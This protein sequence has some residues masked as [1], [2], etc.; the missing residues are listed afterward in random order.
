MV[1]SL[2]YRIGRPLFF[3][4]GLI[5]AVGRFFIFQFHLIPL[6]FKRPF[7]FGLMVRQLEAIGA[8]SLLVVGLTAVFTGMVMAIQL[9][10]AFNKFGAAEMMGYAIFLA[11]GRELGPVFTALML[12]SRAVS[13]MAA[14]LGTMRVTEQIDAI[15]VLSVDS[16]HYLM[17]PRIWAAIIAMPLLVMFF[18]VIANLGAYLLAV[19]ALDVNPTA[20]MR[21]IYQFSEISDFM[22]GFVKGVVFGL[23]VSAIGTYVGYHARGGAKGVGEATTQAVVIASV[24]LFLTNYF[25]SS[26]FLLLDW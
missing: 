11:I 9:Y 1:E 10:V 19:Y 21:T 16:R 2:L 15:E 26:L 6:F 8:S 24:A 14:E 22:Q 7:R 17:I 25:L 23:V 5:E 20:Y 3:V 12:I 13:A 18:D 4:S